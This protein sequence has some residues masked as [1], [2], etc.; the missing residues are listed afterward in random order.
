MVTYNSDFGFRVSSNG[1]DIGVPFSI[2]LSTLTYGVHAGG[3]P[4][5]LGGAISAFI[6]MTVRG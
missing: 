1:V 4:I 3:V 5:K 6:C 2:S